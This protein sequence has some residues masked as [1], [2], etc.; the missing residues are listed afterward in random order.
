MKVFLVLALAALAQARPKAEA[1]GGYNYRAPPPPQSSYT[2]AS[3]SSYAPT[4][5]S[6]YSSLGP[7]YGVPAT[8]QEPTVHKHIYV[9]LAPQEHEVQAPRARPTFAPPQKHYKIVFIKAPTPPTP[10]QQTVELPPQDEEKTLI[11]VLVKKPEEQPEVKVNVPPPTP[12]SKPEVYFIKYKA[13]KEEGYPN[14]IA[15]APAN[16]IH[17][18][19]GIITDARGAS[20]IDLP[21]PAA[22]SSSYGTPS[23]PARS[24]SSSYG[25][26]L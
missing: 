8:R 23:G 26:P 24:P 19:D 15:P 7:A 14:S 17:A 2:S 22:P 10:T 20:G 11:Y 6:S 25:T 13:Q 4:G 12:P 9:H 5:P 3:A 16:P 18:D 1:P 21:I